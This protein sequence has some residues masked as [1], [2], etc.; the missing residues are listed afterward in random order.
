MAPA[1]SAI[2]EWR[3]YGLVPVVAALGYATSVLHIYSIGPFIEPLQNEFGWSRAQV[4]SGISIAAFASGIFCIPVGM[5]VDRVG[6]RRVGLVGVP[7]MALAVALLG[8]ATGDRTNWILLWGIAALGSLWVQA[9]VWTSAVTSRFHA[10]RGLALAITLS[11]AS[12]AA[13]AFPLLATWLIGD[14]GWRFAYMA[15]SGIWALLVFPLILLFFHGA[16]DE[17][18]DRA[19]ATPAANPALTGLSLAEG[20]RTSA[21]YKL[22]LASG[23][24]T[25]TI[26]A[27]VVHFVPILTD[28]GADPLAAAGIASL[29]GV[30]SIIGRLGAGFLLDR[31]PAHKVGAFIF[32]LPVIAC[33]L[34]LVDGGSA[35]SQSVAAAIVGLT[36]GSEVDVMAYLAARYFGLKNFG[37]LYGALLMALSLGTALGP[38]A[39][40]AVFDQHGSYAVFLEWT[41]VLTTASAIALISLGATPAADDAP[42]PGAGPG[43]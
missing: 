5:L 23:L 12:V 41:M 31:F 30:F 42:G 40:G 38:L 2:A 1:H 25:F 13:T 34:L 4:S 15:T 43:R 33:V 11:G 16:Q 3:R 28:S 27:I 22:L 10:S 26:L 39:A 20:L 18:R 37:A 6:P 8:T 9:T 29:V 21:L 32:L 17:G 19:V 14:H 24:F 7:L 35:V 36:L